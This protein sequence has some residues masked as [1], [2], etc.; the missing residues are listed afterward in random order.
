[1]EHC[2]QAFIGIDVAKLRNAIAAAEGARGGEV[3]FIGEVDASDESMRRTLKRI[4]EKYD[5]KCLAIKCDSE[6][7]RFT[8][9]LDPS[10]AYDQ[11]DG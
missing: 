4:A 7:R 5:R 1:M 6:L 8:N 9:R 3:R 10:F 11:G 2:T